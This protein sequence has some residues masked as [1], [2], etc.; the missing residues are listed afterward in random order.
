MN[1]FQ[2]LAGLILDLTTDTGNN[3]YNSCQMSHSNFHFWS[4]MLVLS[5]LSNV[6]CWRGALSP[7]LSAS[8]FL[9]RQ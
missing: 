1:V 9:A 6:D 7:V 3:D 5:V 8:D 2:I 4:N